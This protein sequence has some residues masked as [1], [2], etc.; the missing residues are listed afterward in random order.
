MLTGR[1]SLILEPEP[2]ELGIFPAWSFPEPLSRSS[3]RCGGRASSHTS[4][5]WFRS[6]SQPTQP[7][8]CSW[9]LARPSGACPSRGIPGAGARHWSPGDILAM[10]VAPAFPKAGRGQ[11]GKWLESF[12]CAHSLFC[13]QR[14]IPAADGIN[15]RNDSALPL[16][17]G[18]FWC[19]TG[20]KAVGKVCFPWTCS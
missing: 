1:I 11:K 2:V 12:S 16:L 9:G 5:R 19:G 10:G 15:P 18:Q 14:P 7:F 8:Q 13:F 6:S 3:R 17:Q 4:A 20:V